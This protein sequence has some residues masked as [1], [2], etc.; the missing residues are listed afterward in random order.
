MLGIKNKA[1]SK[2]TGNILGEATGTW[3]WLEVKG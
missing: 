3:N 1:G 2:T